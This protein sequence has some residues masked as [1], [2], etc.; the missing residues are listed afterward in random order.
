MRTE[1][2][3]P[4]QSSTYRCGHR[5][6]LAKTTTMTIAGAEALEAASHGA[7]SS[8]SSSLSSPTFFLFPSGPSTS[9]LASLCPVQSSSPSP[10]SP[11]A[12]A[13][14]RS[15]CWI[16]VKA[17][18][19]SCFLCFDQQHSSASASAPYAY[20]RHLPP[21]RSLIT[22]CLLHHVRRDSLCV[23]VR[24][25]REGSSKADRATDML[26]A[27]HCDPHTMRTH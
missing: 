11:P 5:R 4:C 18:F 10:P 25:K 15:F 23:V 12:L 14:R 2:S 21:L 1:T 13:Q 22:V 16:A 7:S 19:A 17:A 24:S 27:P 8:S 20:P 6:G 26:K 3:L 9:L